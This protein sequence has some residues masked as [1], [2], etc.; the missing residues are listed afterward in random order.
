MSKK[1]KLQDLS[2][3]RFNQQPDLEGIKGGA[4]CQNR[5]GK[6]CAFYVICWY[7]WYP[8]CWDKTKGGYY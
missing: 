6:I 3:S 1:I 2:I 7:G 5:F 4:Y 8:V